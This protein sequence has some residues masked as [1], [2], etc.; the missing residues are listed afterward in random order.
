MVPRE[1]P[2]ARS[3]AECSQSGS[4][5]ERR[6]GMTGPVD[7]LERH[8]QETLEAIRGLKDGRNAVNFPALHLLFTAKSENQRLYVT[9]L[10]STGF[11]FRGLVMDV[12]AGRERFSVLADDGEVVSGMDAG[13]ILAVRIQD[14]I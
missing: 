6:K 9:A 1:R 10:D 7:R 12:D 2:D 5:S 11:F 13:Q 14:K 4:H 3:L 8:L